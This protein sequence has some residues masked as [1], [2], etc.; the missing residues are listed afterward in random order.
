MK[1]KSKEVVRVVPGTNFAFQFRPAS[2]Q[3]ESFKVR[4]ISNK[5]LIVRRHI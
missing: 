2:R 1:L 4:K 3:D 5:S